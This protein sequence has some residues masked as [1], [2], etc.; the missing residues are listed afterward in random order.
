MPIVDFACEACGGGFE[1]PVLGRAVPACPHGT[2][3]HRGGAKASGA[4]RVTPLD[5][6]VRSLSKPWCPGHGPSD[7]LRATYA[8]FFSIMSA[9]CSAPSTQ[10][11]ASE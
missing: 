3:Q 9:V 7:K 6:F 11:C 1:Q 4:G 2:G 5:P 10:P 8:I